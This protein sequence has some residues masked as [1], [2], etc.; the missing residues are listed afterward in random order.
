MS[1]KIP[2]NQFVLQLYVYFH[3]ISNRAGTNR[4]LQW[5]MVGSGRVE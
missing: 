3:G 4:N 1:I 5:K 2:T